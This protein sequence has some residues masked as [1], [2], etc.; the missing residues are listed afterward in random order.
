MRS[1]R[2]NNHHLKIMHFS[3]KT[4]Y[5]HFPTNGHKLDHPVPWV[6]LQ[7]VIVIFPNHTHL[8]LIKMKSVY[9]KPGLNKFHLNMINYTYKLYN[10]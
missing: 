5:L 3:V 2:Y 4:I 7:F 9:V 10:L 1:S 6:G 8:L